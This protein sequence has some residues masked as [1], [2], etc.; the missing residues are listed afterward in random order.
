M[1]FLASLALTSLVVTV[2]QDPP[3]AAQERAALLTPAE[4]AA[5][6]DKLVKYLE[7][8][9]AYSRAEGVKDREKTNKVREKTKDAFQK[10]WETRNKKVN[11]LAS[12]AD[13]RAIFDNCFAVPAPKFTP[14]TMRKDKLK[15]SSLES[16][17]YLPKAY[18]ADKAM[19]TLLVL[20]G[21]ATAEQTNTWVDGDRWF[22]AVW[23]KTTV[24][25]D[26]IVHMSYLPS[27]STGIEMDPA[28]DFSREGQDAQE[29]KRIE[30]VFSTFGATMAAVNVDRAR[31]FLDCARGNCAFGLRFVSMFPDRFAGVILRHPTA[32]DEL[33]LGSLHGMP[34]LM[35]KSAANAAVVDALKARLEQLT[36]GSVTVVDATDEYP[37]KGAAAAIEGWMQK[38]RRT[39]Y[40]AHV[41]IE[42]NHDRF[43]RAYWVRMGPMNPLHTAPADQKPRI[44]VQ[45]DRA[46]NRIVVSARGVENFTLLLND[47][48]VDLDKEF[49]VVVNDKAVTEKRTRDMRG[50]QKRLV[51]RRDWDFL[52][53]VM[54][55]STVP[56]PS[57]AG[58]KGAD[59]KGK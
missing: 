28:P 12:M 40:P 15:D 2:P 20:P 54:Y 50:M 29:G 48:L 43:N 8:D 1:A 39:M 9:E 49:T 46:T 34:V 14:G 59:S 35:I 55:E 56:K 47:D 38:Q 27:G 18:K 44:E 3:Q 10:E 21:T 33:R 37:H 58:D 52:F 7:A 31:V 16:A 41:I 32:V 19:R 22:E 4:H 45:A 13:L 5:L 23:D 30:A 24:L 11:V 53:P 51:E 57:A 26:T 6:R 36:P 42:P 25:A 17:L